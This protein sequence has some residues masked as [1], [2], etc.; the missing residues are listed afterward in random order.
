ME[1]VVFL[2]DDS[3]T[4]RY[5]ASELVRCLRVMLKATVELHVSNTP[6]HAGAEVISLGLSSGFPESI[7]KGMSVSPDD[8]AILVRI[9]KLVFLK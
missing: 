6:C 1:R 5:A 9:R 2:T 7:V 3:D 4:T 8:D